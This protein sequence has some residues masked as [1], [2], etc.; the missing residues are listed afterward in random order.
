MGTRTSY[1]DVN[2]TNSASLFSKLLSPHPDG[3]YSSLLPLFFFR[4]TIDLLCWPASTVRFVIW[5]VP[6]ENPFELVDVLLPM[7]EGN[8]VKS[9]IMRMKINIG[10]I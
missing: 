1:L 5:N 8:R 7:T 2:N 4:A 6:S 10:Q 3:C 9:A